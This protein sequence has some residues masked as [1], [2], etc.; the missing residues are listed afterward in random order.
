M[1]I[2]SKASSRTFC[3]FSF[4][5]SR[6]SRE[7]SRSSMVISSKFVDSSIAVQHFQNH[8]STIAE[9]SP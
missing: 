6:A 5:Y 9:F 3:F 2:F 7:V 1:V 8:Q 4:R